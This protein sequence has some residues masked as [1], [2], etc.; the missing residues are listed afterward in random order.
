M[1][2]NW[3]TAQKPYVILAPMAGYTDSSFRQ[4]IKEIAPS[5]ICI[6]ELI[7]ADGIAYGGKKTMEMLK[8]D[9][10]ERPN[11]LQLFGKR[12]EHFKEAVKIAEDAGFD[13]VDINMGCPARKVIG[14]MHGSALI[15][16][17]ELAFE[18]IETCAKNTKLPVS[19]KTRL[20]W[21]DDSTL[22]DFTKGL[23]SAGAQMITI[24]GRTTKQAFSGEANWDPIYRVKEKLS[25]PVTGNGDIKSG[26]D[27]KAK[28][29]NLD[30]IMVGRGTFGNPWLMGEVCLA[31]GIGSASGG[32][33]GHR[34]KDF[35]ELKKF[36]IHHAEISIKVHGQKKGIRDIRK[37]FAS[38]I[39][40]FPGAAKLRS[41]LVQ[42]ESIDEVKE[43]LSQ[44]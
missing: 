4:I 14:S 35:D 41:Q 34:P 19:V 13:G 16:T 42:V 40:G 31:L 22:D 7:S 43:I 44:I 2:F 15:K 10:I 26:E 12:V 3:N 28:L 9:K 18:I 27:A 5:T 17:P 30:G 8:F 29:K 21:E 36:M 38:Y 37:H 23:E 11:I 20:G 33:I 39:Q 32:D 6:T 24:H 25:I 1:S